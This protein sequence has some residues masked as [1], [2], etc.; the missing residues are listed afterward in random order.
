MTDIPHPDSVGQTGTGTARHPY[1]PDPG[2]A[3]LELEGENLD[4]SISGRQFVKESRGRL[5]ILFWICVGWVSFTILL[6]IAAPW[7]HF[8]KDPAKTDYFHENIGPSAAHWC[9]VDDQGRDI[10]SRLVWG[11]RL[12]LGVG[13]ASMILAYAIGGT[14]GMFM[15]YRRGRMDTVT[16]SGMYVIQA[17]PGLVLV[18]A[19]T[20]FL[21]P[22]TEIKLIAIISL[23]AIPLVFRV[24][25][26]STISSAT[27][28]Y[29]VAAK[30][31]GATDR[32]ILIK[33]LFP[34]I[35]PTAVSFFLIG[36]AIVIALEGS[37][38]YLGLSVP[39]VPSWGNMINEARNIVAQ[40]PWLAFFPA[41]EICLFLLS[42]NFMGDRLRSYFDV[43]EVKL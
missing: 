38:A 40:N 31:Q 24:I 5:G 33:E 17:F 25:R 39:D 16:S 3:E 26:A 21:K 7:L 4:Q 1:P 37:L 10:C 27:R 36:V 14:L 28:E 6:A 30:V 41:I 15:A 29:V 20:Q 13:F 11:S 9:G 43:T 23:V 32:R 34:N 22:I 2:L 12:S 42:L 8:L 19:L 35:L 18:I